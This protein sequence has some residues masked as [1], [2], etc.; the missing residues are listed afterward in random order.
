MRLDAVE[1][2]VTIAGDRV[3]PA[4]DMFGLSR[5]RPEWRIYVADDVAQ[6][7]SP[8]TPLLDAGVILRAREWEAVL[9]SDVK[10]ERWT[11]HGGTDFLE[12]SIVPAPDTAV[13][14]QAALEKFVSDRGFVPA[15]WQIPKTS[16][17]LEE[18]AA[19]ET[20]G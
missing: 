5:D 13:E 4:V 17:V 16:L 14:K 20:A 1:V 18:L 10:A 7:T 3:E 8:R 2:K 11:L 9:G 12:L 15:P 19:S 6:L